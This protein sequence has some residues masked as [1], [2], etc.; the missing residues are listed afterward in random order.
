ML[1]VALEEGSGAS[2]V[3]TFDLAR[4]VPANPKLQV[5]R[6]VCM[7][8]MW[9]WGAFGFMGLGWA[10]RTCMGLH[11]G[12]VMGVGGHSSFAS[13]GGL[14]AALA[15]PHLWHCPGPRAC[16]TAPASACVRCPRG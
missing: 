11:M 16:G 12:P 3:D 7:L 13:P 15:L 4:V 1:Q 8:C 5:G 2:K 9:A 6:A 10:H 14:A